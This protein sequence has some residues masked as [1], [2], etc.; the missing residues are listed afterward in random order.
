MGS[1]ISGAGRFRS[2]GVV[3]V[4]A[5][6][7]GKAGSGTV[8]AVLRF[9]RGKASRIQ[10]EKPST[11]QCSS[12]LGRVFRDLLDSGRRDPWR[13]LRKCCGDWKARGE[14]GAAD[15]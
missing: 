10:R 5:G 2:A 6:P 1:R 15:S 8:G 7:H 3:R 13:D 4:V 11:N 12:A 14:I 9:R